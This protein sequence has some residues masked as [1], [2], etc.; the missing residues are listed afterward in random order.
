MFK[1]YK[2]SIHLG[3]TLHPQQIEYQVEVNDR[4]KISKFLAIPVMIAGAVVG[5]LVFSV[6]FVALL[7]PFGFIAYRAWR[8]IRTAQQQ[9][10]SQNKGESLA[11]EYT[12][13]SDKDQK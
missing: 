2:R 4:S 6:F 9:S 8:L 11:A 5:T 12:V 7:I 3:T 13:I 10:V 1:V